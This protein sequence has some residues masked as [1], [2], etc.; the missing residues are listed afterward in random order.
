MRS[1]A[2]KHTI[3]LAHLARTIAS[4]G[5]PFDTWT[6]YA[7]VKAELVEHDLAEVRSDSA[8]NETDTLSF[9]IRERSGVT[10][11]DRLTYLG[12]AYNIVA[13]GF[14]IRT[15]QLKAERVR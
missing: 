4:T 12:V 5:A 1:G 15:L 3:T 6:D 10:T 13:V 2:L 7:T 14:G 9:R 8:A 11:D